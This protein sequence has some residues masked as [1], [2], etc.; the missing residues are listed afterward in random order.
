MTY[1]NTCFDDAVQKRVGPFVVV[2]HLKKTTQL[3]RC[4]SRLFFIVIVDL[5]SKPLKP[6]PTCDNIAIYLITYYSNFRIETLL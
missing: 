2:D 1:A 6:Y 4:S 3:R 5:V